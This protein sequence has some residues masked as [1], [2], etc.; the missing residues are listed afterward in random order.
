MDKLKPP[1]PEVVDPKKK[2]AKKEAKKETKEAPKKDAKKDDK[3]KDNKKKGG[4]VKI[5]EPLRDE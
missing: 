2:G 5:A 1:E 3:K 4:E